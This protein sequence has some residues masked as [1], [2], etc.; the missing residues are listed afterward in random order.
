MS[1]LKVKAI[2]DGIQSITPHL[3]CASA[4]EAVDFYKKAFNA[5]EQVRLPGPGGKLMHACVLIGSSQ[6][7]L[8]E[9]NPQWG[10]L[11][12]KTLKGSPITIHLQVENADETMAQAVAAGA[13][14]TKPIS[15]M[16]WGDR[17][18]QVEDPFGHRWAIATHVRDVTPQEMQQAMAKL[19]AS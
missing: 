16:F 18:G 14:V 11:G 13:K 4:S 6:L 17:Y 12:P 9:E 8:A 10:A 2:P 7:M 3:I 5:V 19:G 1:D 15:E